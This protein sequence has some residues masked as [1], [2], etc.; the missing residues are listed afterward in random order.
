MYTDVFVGLAHSES[1]DF[2]VP[3][4]VNGYMPDILY[5]RDTEV[6]PMLL[7]GRDKVYWDLVGNTFCKKLDWGS[8]GLKLKAKDMITFLKKYGQNPF[9]HYLIGKIKEDFIDNGLEDVELV[10]DAVETEL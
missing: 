10:L 6:K 5:G 3:G 9:A 7:V 2:D 8:W 4:N 1:F